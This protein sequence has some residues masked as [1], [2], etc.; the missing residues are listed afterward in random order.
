MPKTANLC[1]AA[2]ALYLTVHPAMAKDIS[3]L[4]TGVENARQEMEQAKADYDNSNEQIARTQRNVEEQ[5][6]KLEEAKRE[7]EEAKKNAAETKRAYQAARAK[8]EKAHSALK[9]A[10]KQ[11]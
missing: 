7:W 6:Q 8:Y 9:A 3:A 5:K 10:W 4:Q 2:L 11:Q 1:I